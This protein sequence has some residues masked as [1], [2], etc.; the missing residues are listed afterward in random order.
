MNYTGLITSVGEGVRMSI[1]ECQEQF[2]NRKWNC[3]VKE[4]GNTVFGSMIRR[5][6][7]SFSSCTLGFAPIL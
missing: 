1:D 6:K 2:K 4:E 3:S 5:G 7:R